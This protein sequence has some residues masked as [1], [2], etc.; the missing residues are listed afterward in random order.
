MSTTANTSA[1]TPAGAL[2][3]RLIT[4]PSG[5]PYC[6]YQHVFKGCI[7]RATAVAQ[8][9]GYPPRR[10]TLTRTGWPA[11]PSSAVDL[12]AGTRAARVPA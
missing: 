9:G 2:N 4:T 7:D 1:S 11:R 3:G 6:W 5:H 8:F 10:H 12:Y